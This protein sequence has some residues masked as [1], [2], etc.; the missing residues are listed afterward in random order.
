MEEQMDKNSSFEVENQQDLN[1]EKR[2]QE[3][4]KTDYKDD[5]YF[6][7]LFNDENY[8][9]IYDLDNK[10]E[11]LVKEK[12]TKNKTIKNKSIDKSIKEYENEIN[13]NDLDKLWKI[14]ENKGKV[15]SKKDYLF[16]EESNKIENEKL[17]REQVVETK[18]K[19]HLLEKL[20]DSIDYDSVNLYQN[21]IKQNKKNI[22]LI[23]GLVLFFFFILLGA[24]TFYLLNM[25]IFGFGRLVNDIKEND[26]IWLGIFGGLALL[27]LFSLAFYIPPL[28]K[29][30][31]KLTYFIK[32]HIAHSLLD[33][34][35]KWI[36]LKKYAFNS[37][38][39]LDFVNTSSMKVWVGKMT[40]PD[41]PHNRSVKCIEYSHN[42]IYRNINVNIQDAELQYHDGSYEKMNLDKMR[43]DDREIVN[44]N[45]NENV[46]LLKIIE[47]DLKKSKF[48]EYD[49]PDF[50]IFNFLES[51]KT[52]APE[53]LYKL[54]KYDTNFDVTFNL[55]TNV[56]KEK[57]ELLINSL[58][59]FMDDKFFARDYSH[60]NS[61][62]SCFNKKIIAVLAYDEIKDREEKYWQTLFI[63]N[64][65]P[66][67]PSD[68]SSIDDKKEVMF[69]DN[70]EVDKIRYCDLLTY[71]EQFATFFAK[72]HTQIEKSLMPLIKLVAHLVNK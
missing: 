66:F 12:E 18:I 33:N 10:V 72:I 27:D 15:I 11:L 42:Y 19:R 36:D 5:E 43:I 6:N 54:K 4:L 47:L 58:D 65:V 45:I 25:F 7:D 20:K 69:S 51:S 53:N 29:R 22:D 37:L 39:D 67:N 46:N 3:A 21:K 35:I 9:G 49:I 64:F 1:K 41:V 17:T 55:Q 2:N 14:Y 48:A 63:N 59:K 38:V 61:S 32:E 16:P 68:Y 52:S 71:L 28:K 23:T 62:I 31:K 34:R 30:N 40:Y 70:N 60:S 24:I 44:P 50:N 57:Q 8:S 56:P 26:Y 13:K